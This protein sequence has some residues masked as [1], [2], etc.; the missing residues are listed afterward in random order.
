MM[1]DNTLLFAKVHPDAKIP[2]KSA[3][4]A[5]YDVYACFDEDFMIIPSFSTVM[6][7]TGIASAMSEK[8]YIQIEERGSTGSKGMKKSAGVIDSSYR[9]EWFI[10][11]TN[12][13]RKDIFISKLPKDE[14]FDK[15]GTVVAETIVNGQEKAIKTKDIWYV[16]ETTEVYPYNKAIAQAVVH[17]VPVMDVEEIPYN[18][19]KNIPSE[20]GDG[21]LGSTG[22]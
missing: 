5:G 4:N 17:E 3:G 6:I 20:R 8:Y 16:K 19:L 2:A 18:E 13:D 21:K 1:K 22:K 10:A 14:L 15:Y 12:C 11:I 7:P 9:G